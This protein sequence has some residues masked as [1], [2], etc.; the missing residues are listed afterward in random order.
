MIEKGPRWWDLWLT[1]P[2]FLVN[3][4]LWVACID[5]L[6]QTLIFALRHIR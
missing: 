5:G 4:I 1:M 3:A 2:M 6:L